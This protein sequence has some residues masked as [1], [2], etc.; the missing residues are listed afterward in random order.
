MRSR[1]SATRRLASSS[2]V[3]SA[4]S[5]RSL[6]ASTKAR[7]LRTASPAAAAMPVQ[8]KMPRF[9]WAYQGRA[10][11]SIAT[12]VRPAIVTRP[13][14]QVVER[15]VVA[16]TVNSAMTA[17]ITTGARGSPVSSSVMAAA[18]V[19]ARTVQGARR[20]KTRAQAP[21]VISRRLRTAG[22]W[23]PQVGPC[24]P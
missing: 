15:S 8:A 21:S 10:P 1:S 7:R 2:L 4:R 9:S 5:A 19:A 12:P 13:I 14:R 11:D 17:H 23:V 16:A 22:V 18:Q 6:M 3:R 24:S 20:R